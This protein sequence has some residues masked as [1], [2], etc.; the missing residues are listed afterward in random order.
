MKDWKDNHGKNLKVQI[1][2]WRNCLVRYI[3]Y[4]CD[5]AKV[6]LALYDFEALQAFKRLF[7]SFVYLKHEMKNQ[8]HVNET[9]T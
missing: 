9:T 5:V 6:Q 7:E 4:N 1:V 8:I 2:F 3:M